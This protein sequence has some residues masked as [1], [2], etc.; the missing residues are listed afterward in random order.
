MA[1]PYEVVNVPGSEDLRILAVSKSIGMPT[2]KAIGSK[3]PWWM[4]SIKG[5][6]EL[7]SS[8]VEGNSIYKN[9]AELYGFQID[10]SREVSSD[11]SN[12]LFTSAMIKHE[13]CIVLIPNGGYI[14]ELENLMNS[15]K[16]ITKVSIQGTGWYNNA[17]KPFTTIVFDNCYII[18]I[19]HDLDRAFVRFR[20]QDKTHT[21]FVHDQKGQS[22]GQSICTVMLGD[23]TNSVE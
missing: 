15:G 19:T 23:N 4:I 9:Y 2:E 17:L 3:T 10:V 21:F 1:Q 6:K 20:V 12:Q 5:E 22:S 11:I 8:T 18:S 7:L 14:A 13:D 16:P